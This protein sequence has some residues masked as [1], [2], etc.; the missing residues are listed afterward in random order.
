MTRPATV[1]V[2]EDQQ[3]NLDLLTYLLHA[4][5]HQTAVARNGVDALRVAGEV[6]PD[7]VIMDIQMPVMDGYETIAEMRRTPQLADTQVV[8]MTAYAMVGD[9][10]RILAAG[11]D[12]YMSKP[13]EP[14]AFVA[15]VKRLLERCTP[16]IPE[17]QP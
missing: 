12:A 9:R 7:L 15:D 2:V 16:P 17:G 1:L 10:E 11:F 5:G 8:A 14:E 3:E 4:F 13:I 6:R